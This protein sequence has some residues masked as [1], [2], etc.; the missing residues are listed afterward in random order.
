MKQKD[1]NI[2]G[3]NFLVFIKIFLQVNIDLL[4][5]FDGLWVLLNL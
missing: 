4:M 2:E 1:P 3:L 5:D